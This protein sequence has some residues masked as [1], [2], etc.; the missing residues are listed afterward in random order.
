MKEF[1]AL[2]LYHYDFIG[3][4]GKPCKGT[5][6]RVCL[7]EFGLE[8]VNGPLNESLEPCSIVKVKLTYKDKRF[9]VIEV[10]K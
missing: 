10:I 8:E 4:D 5:K 1:K 9:R 6:Y 7:D 2:V 3:K